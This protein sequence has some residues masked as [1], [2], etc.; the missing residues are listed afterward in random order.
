MFVKVK[1]KKVYMEIVDQML[2]LIKAKKLSIGEKL[3]P[4]RSLAIELGVSRPPLR[5]AMSALEILGIVESR[6]GKGNFIASSEI[7][8]EKTRIAR[9]LEGQVSPFEL[10]EARRVVEVEIAGLAAEKATEEDIA[11]IERIFEKH[12]TALSDF[13]KAS[14]VDLQFHVAL[15]K[16]TRNPVLMDIFNR[17]IASVLKKDL[18]RK[19]K[20][21]S[22][23]TGNHALK[24][25]GQHVE[26][27]KA[28]R[29]HD[30]EGARRAM[31]NHLRSIEDDFLEESEEQA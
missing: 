12:K 26:I 11:G 8:T 2:A 10:L 21:K 15:V 16:A 5:E 7:A 27:F 1:S 9:E 19:I 23:A 24:Y 17:N 14:A 20:G 13:S 4:E 22:W 6:G 18:W 29:K 3:P 25:F 31:Q 28:V 30:A